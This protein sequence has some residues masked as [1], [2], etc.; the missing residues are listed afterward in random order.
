MTPDRGG[1]GE[2]DGMRRGPGHGI[3]RVKGFRE[4]ELAARPCLLDTPL[5]FSVAAGGEK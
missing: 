3:T 5:G 4:P 1:G 2:L